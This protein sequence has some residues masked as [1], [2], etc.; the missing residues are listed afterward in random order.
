MGFM[1]T[2]ADTTGVLTVIESELAHR[3]ALASNR[4]LR[5]RMSDI[6]GKKLER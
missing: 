6:F 1:I 3:R 4:R 5:R 2:A